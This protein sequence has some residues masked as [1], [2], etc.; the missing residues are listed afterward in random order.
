MSGSYKSG[1]MTSEMPAPRTVRHVIAVGGGRGG[2]GKSTIAINVA[3]YLAQLGRT[4]VL[5]DAD[6]TGA[7][8]HTMLGAAASLD[9]RGSDEDDATEMRTWPTLVQG[10]MLMPQLY[11]PG[12]TSPL[13]PGRKAMWARQLRHLDAD[14]VILDLGAGTA[15][16]TLDLFLTSDT[17]LCVT[18]PEPPSIETTY[19]FLRALFV[20]RVRRM[21][22]KDRFKMRLAERVLLELPPLPR[23]IEFVQ[24]LARYEVS[25]AE[26][27]AK[28]LSV[29]MPRLVV[30]GVRLRSDSE[31]GP[32]ICEMSRR[33]LGIEMDY[34]GQIEQ[35]DSVWLSVVRKRPLLIDSP[36]SK[37]ARNLER[38][39]RR[40]LAL[41]TSRD[42]P[43]ERPTPS[44]IAPKYTL[45]DVLGTTRVSTDEEV[46]RAYKR[47]RAIFQPDGLALTSLLTE[48]QL[49]REVAAIEEAHDT[50]LDPL[51]RR[52]YDL[53]TFPVEEP[54]DR[55]VVED[56][57]S[58]AMAERELLREELAREINPNTD[59]SG[60][61]LAK[62]RESQ[63][64]EIEEIASRTKI[65][66]GYLKAI[67]QDDFAA[68]PALVYTRGFLQQIAKLLG[69]DPAQVTRTYLRR[70]RGYERPSGGESSA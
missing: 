68:L 32:A 6:P 4:V 51:R 25:L 36:T 67:E 38:I 18:T 70:L 62:V 41:S 46:R 66:V 12:S 65:Q 16:A 23:P 39:A 54:T 57:G 35:D 37:S 40:T 63:G 24:A 2:V 11:S 44:I 1:S 59:Y 69:L 19:R 45:Y 17:G 56:D 31:V 60:P 22:A 30:N 5:V 21:L 49:A 27:A 14:Y 58:A 43:R 53:S 13:R 33:Y 47:Q 64:I 3:V 9:A 61:L 42:A 7:E 55:S 29:M 48:E 8:L 15:P 52:A 34:L 28:E 20:R 50:L 26:Q 10:L